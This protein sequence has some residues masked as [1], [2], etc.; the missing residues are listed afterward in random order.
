MISCA[1]RERNGEL[2]KKPCWSYPNLTDMI[3]YYGC[4]TRKLYTPRNPIINDCEFMSVDAVRGSFMCFN[5]K[6]LKLANG[7]PK[8][9]FYAMKRILF[10]AV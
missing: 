6:A 4:I 5:D 10:L 7:L 2:S 3:M 1:I 9:H 8:I